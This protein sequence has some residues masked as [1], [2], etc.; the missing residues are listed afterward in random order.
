MFFG[1]TSRIKLRFPFIDSSFILIAL[2]QTPK[3]QQEYRKETQIVIKE[4]ISIPLFSL[5]CLN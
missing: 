4:F 5:I 1:F 2:N 3:Q